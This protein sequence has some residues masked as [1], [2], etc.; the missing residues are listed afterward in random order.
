MTTIRDL[1]T[2]QGTRM[3]EMDSVHVAIEWKE[4]L[5][6]LGYGLF[7]I[8]VWILKKFGEDHLLSMKELAIELKEMRKELNVLATRVTA[9]EIRTEHIRRDEP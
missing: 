5:K 8:M 6:V 4:V 1:K 7:A 3:N 9:V 2:F